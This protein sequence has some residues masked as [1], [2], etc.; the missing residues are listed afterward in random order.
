M[1]TFIEKE[2][3]Q[4]KLFIVF[5]LILFVGILVLGFRILKKEKV[6][7]EQ[8]ISSYNPQFIE[9]DFSKL[10]NL[11]L[12]DFDDFQ[13]IPQFEE[14]AGRKNPFVSYQSK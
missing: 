10:K 3:K 6:S 14:E 11:N 9:V 7:I 12:K 2:K 4:E 1:A 5:V 13:K 8:E